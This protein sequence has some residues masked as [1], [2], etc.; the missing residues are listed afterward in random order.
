MDKKSIV[1]TSALLFLFLISLDMFF[2]NTHVTLANNPPRGDLQYLAYT[3]GGDF[4]VLNL[5]NITTN[6]SNTPDPT[7]T[8]GTPK[9]IY[10]M[11]HE[12]E[13]LLIYQGNESA[14]VNTTV[15]EHVLYYIIYH[16]VEKEYNLTVKIV[17]FNYT[18]S[19]E[20][21][22]YAL[23]IINFNPTN[24]KTN[25]TNLIEINSTST[26]KKDTNLISKGLN[27]LSKIYKNSQNE[28]LKALGKY[29]EKISKDMKNL[30]KIIPKFILKMTLNYTFSVVKDGSNCNLAAA[31]TGSLCGLEFGIWGAVL[32]PVSF[33][34][35]FLVGVLAGAAVCGYA[36]Y[37]VGANCPNN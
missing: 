7:V 30:N 12:K 9:L 28:T 25:I 13:T 15:N 20:N 17:I 24:H 5:A 3:N 22:Y 19:S 4:H 34:L 35:S 16:K 33:G 6:Q 29:Y 1:S 14:Y 26:L 23:F 2:I 18:L 37:E 11:T 27:K 36:A 10:N 21:G 8:L 31:A 32:A